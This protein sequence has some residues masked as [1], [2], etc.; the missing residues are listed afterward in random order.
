MDVVSGL[1]QCMVSVDDVS[2]SCQL[3]MSVDDVSGLC[4]C[5]CQ[6]KW[7]DLESQNRPNTILKFP[8]WFRRYAGVKWGVAK[9]V[10]L[11]KKIRQSYYNED[12]L[13]TGLLRLVFTQPA[14]RQLY[15]RKYL[16]KMGVWGVRIS[17]IICTLRN[18]R[19]LPYAEFEM[20]SMHFAN[21]L[22]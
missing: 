19:D 7:L 6:S 4:Q 8:D 3:M 1:C 17:T 9:G 20:F 11:V 21:F 15:K 5:L 13:S 2:A 18:G 12:L 14:T 10:G 22:Q 16:Q